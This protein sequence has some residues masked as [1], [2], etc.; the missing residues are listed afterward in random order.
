MT[1]HEELLD[2][3]EEGTISVRI[4]RHEPRQDESFEGGVDL[5]TGG[6]VWRYNWHLLR[7][8]YA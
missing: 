7:F 4:A 5:H 3:F 6:P 2:G 1:S 8:R